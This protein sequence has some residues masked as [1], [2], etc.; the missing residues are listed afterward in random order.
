[1]TA[2]ELKQEELISKLIDFK[3]WVCRHD[4]EI[5]ASQRGFNYLTDIH[6][7]E[8]V[9]WQLKKFSLESESVASTGTITQ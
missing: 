8:Y 4:K 9:V 3:G 6:A 2:L 7:L 1:M 5:A